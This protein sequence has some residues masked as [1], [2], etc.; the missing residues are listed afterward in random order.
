MI[1]LYGMSSPN[2]Q[3]VVLMLE[4]TRLPYRFNFVNVFRGEQFDARFLAL[5]PNAKVPVIVDPDGPDGKPFTLFESG[6]ILLYLA[7]K[8]GKFWPTEPRARHTVTQWLMIQMGGIGPMSGQYIHFMRFAPAGNEY[9]LKR[10]GTEVKR[11]HGVME[12]RLG[13]S[14]YFGGA[15]YG[16][17]DMAFWPWMRNPIVAASMDQYPNLARW[18]AAIAER[19]AAQRMQAWLDG[20]PRAN[21]TQL[22]AEHPDDLDRYFGRGKYS[23][24]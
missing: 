15:D 8:T 10:Y 2:V 1:E 20:V 14:A 13:E 11:L 23:R 19:P 9:G 7:E 17:A 21:F 16:I 6:A 22:Q 12:Q 3:K 24:V 5:N 18:S 4:E